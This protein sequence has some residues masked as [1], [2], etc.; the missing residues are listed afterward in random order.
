MD[1]CH[2]ISICKYN[3]SRYICINVTDFSSMFSV[4]KLSHCVCILI[5]RSIQK[6]IVTQRERSWEIQAARVTRSDFHE[7]AFPN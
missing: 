6:T 3:K 7:A 2:L 1:G 4:L 5:G